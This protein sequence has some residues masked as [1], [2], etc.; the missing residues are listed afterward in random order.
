MLK[1]MPY[2]NKKTGEIISDEEFNTRIGKGKAE[3]AL[4][5]KPEEESLLTGLGGL[6]KYTGENILGLPATEEERKARGI[7]GEMVEK[8]I[9][10]KG[11]AGVFQLPGKAIAQPGLLKE[12]TELSE[13]TGRLADLTTKMIQRR[14]TLTDPER[15]AKYDEI[16]KGN[17]E[18]LK[19]AGMDVSNLE[20]SILKPTEAIATTLRAGTFVG[21]MIL[22][23]PG[24][25]TGAA[26]K[27]GITGAGYNAAEAIE[28][29]EKPTEVMRQ[30]AIGA[31]I[32][33]A[34][35]VAFY[36]LQQGAEKLARGIYKQIAQ[37]GK[38][39][40]PEEMADILVDK[41]MATSAGN[42]K[43]N[44]DKD[45]KTQNSLID[46]ILGREP[47]KKYTQE[48]IFD[49]STE[50][51]K[52]AQR[53][54]IQRFFDIKNFR[55]DIEKVLSNL[56]IKIGGKRLN[57][58][59]MNELRKEIDRKLGDKAFQ[60]F[61]S[62]NPN[63]QQ[64][65]LALRRGL[66]NMVKTNA[67]D[68]VE[69]FNTMSPLVDTSKALGLIAD[70]AGK[71][72]PITAFEIGSIGGGMAYPPVMPYAISWIGLKRAAVTGLLPALTAR[73]ALLV[74]DIAKL[75]NYPQTRIL[76]WQILGKKL[77]GS[78]L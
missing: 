63:S 74:S 51:G 20:K 7:P 29:G 21:S 41:K 23:G 4:A 67:P 42:M 3:P 64:A 16:I 71:R 17:F 9:G 18:E 57:L 52:E 37:W 30:T 50:Q 32:G 68:T 39:R 28:A 73:G 45:I 76:L 33:A 2:K 49:Q 26:I 1:T 36:A 61:F 43:N 34:T 40:R 77:G 19:N 78:E 75:A 11:V 12:Q 54:G 10:R 70:R 69:V 5:A 44:I 8:T 58:T 46:K 66:E 24:S 47:I 65:L 56:N 55:S 15:V 31:G 38:A 59:E 53:E 62:E 27:G 72:M 60:K 6:A 35:G 48:A 14:R 22:G 13:S 25:Y